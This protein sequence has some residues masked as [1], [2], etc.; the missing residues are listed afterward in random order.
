MA[1]SNQRKV[2]QT[3]D[4]IIEDLQKYHRQYQD[5][6]EAVG[7]AMGDYDLESEPG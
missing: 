3:V 7:F 5:E 1:T 6:K 4:E 2:T